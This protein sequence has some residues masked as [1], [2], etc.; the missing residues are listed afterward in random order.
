M[1]PIATDVTRSVVC[2]SVL[3]TRMYP[4]N[5]AEPIEMPFGADSV[6][7]RNC[8]VDGGKDRT[9]EFAATRGEKCFVTG[10]VSEI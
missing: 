9:N 8:V 4:A 5:T 7:P 3:V 10:T 6:G 2:L 1:R